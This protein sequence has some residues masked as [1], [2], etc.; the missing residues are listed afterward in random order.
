VSDSVGGVVVAIDGPSGSGKSSVARR[1]AQTLGLRYLDTGAL[2]RA[3]TLAVLRSG[4]PVTDAAEVTAAARATRVDVATDPGSTHVRLGSEDV[5]LEIRGP[6]VTSAVSV[7]SAVPDVRAHLLQVQRAVV[8]DALEHG[9]GIVVEG[10]D[11]GSVVL[12]EATVKVYLTASPEVRALRRAAE[13]E[14]RVGGTGDV[15]TTQTDLLRRDR[16]DS[17][18]AVSPLTKA[19]D[20]VEIDATKLTLKQVVDRVCDL[21]RDRSAVGST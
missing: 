21:V 8:Q 19:P 15:T 20:A 11:I 14:A 12:P 3:V 16:H 13:E 6:Q 1:V 2:Y 18:R 10:R 9:A 17:G 4:V 7:V 5:S